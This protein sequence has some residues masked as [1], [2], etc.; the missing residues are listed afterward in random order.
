MDI[1]RQLPYKIVSYLKRLKIEYD[2]Y[3]SELFSKIVSSAKVFV[4]GPTRTYEDP[5]FN[6]V[7]RYSYDIV[8]FLP[9]SI[10]EEILPRQSR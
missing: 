3:E 7:Y 10:M 9:V 5:D 2:Q 1:N 6:D 4:R 8:F